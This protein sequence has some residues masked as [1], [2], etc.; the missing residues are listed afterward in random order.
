[1]D[2]SFPA[3]GMPRENDYKVQFFLGLQS[4]FKATF[5]TKNTKQ[6]RDQLRKCLLSVPEVLGSIT[7]I[8]HIE[9]ELER[10]KYDVSSLQTTSFSSLLFSLFI[11]HIMERS[12]K[13][14]TLFFDDLANL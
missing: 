1:M 3:I 4:E 8:S 7:S 14:Q 11:L 6:R 9:K 13:N 5:F 12:A 2:L 10:T